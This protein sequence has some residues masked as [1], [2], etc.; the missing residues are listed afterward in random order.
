[1]MVDMV[2]TGGRLRPLTPKMLER[3]KSGLS[4]GQ[5]V[6]AEFFAT[7]DEKQRSDRA[8]RLLH[9]LINRYAKAL[10]S[11]APA[12]KDELCCL[13]GVAMKLPEDLTTVTLPTWPGH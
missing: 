1:M 11:S 8:F 9:A 6:T 13:Y 4:D 10:G 3:F 7:S 12:A 5:K 2:Y